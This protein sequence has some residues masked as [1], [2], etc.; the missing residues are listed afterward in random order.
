MNTSIWGAIDE[1]G[2]Y[3]PIY[4]SSKETLTIP[5]LTK[6]PKELTIKYRLAEKKYTNVDWK[7]NL[8]DSKQK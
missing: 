3:Y 1:I 4:Q 5:D 6:M 7:V 8:T 2:K